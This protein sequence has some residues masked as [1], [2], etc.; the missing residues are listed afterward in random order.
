MTDLSKL[1]DAEIMA[2]VNAGGNVQPIDAASGEALPEAQAQTYRQLNAVGGIDPGAPGGSARLPLAQRDP[3]D[4]PDPGMFYVATDGRVMQAPKAGV[5]TMVDNVMRSTARGVPLLGNWA[6]EGSAAVNAAVAP[7]VE[8]LLRGLE[9]LGVPTPYDDAFRLDEGKTFGDRYATALSLQKLRD[10]GFDNA[11][12]TTSNTAKGVGTVGGIVAGAL[13]TP[14]LAPASTAAGA[15]AGLLTRMGA[16]AI[17]GGILGGIQGAGTGYG[18]ITDPSRAKAAGLEG[19]IG[20]AGGGAFPWVARGLGNA[21]NAT[22][23][24]V[25]A[26]ALERGR[27]GPDVPAAVD[28]AA[29]AR[30]TGGTPGMP[31]GLAE[32]PDRELIDILATL[33]AA[34]P[35]PTVPAEASADAYARI[36]RAAR[37]QGQTPQELADAVTA[38]GNRGVL[39]DTGQSMQDLTRAAM[40][41][42]SG[43]EDIVRGNLDLR[44]MGV[45]EGGTYTAR[46]S[47]LRIVDEAAAGLGANERSYLGN[48]DALNKIQKEAADPLYAQ[49]REIGATDSVRLRD[50]E[51]RPS[52]QKAKAR[53]YRLAK[54]DGRNPEDLALVSVESPDNWV[55]T[56]P[57]EDQAVLQA[58]GVVLKRAPSKANSQGRSLTKFIADN[59]GIRDDGGELRALDGE[60]WHKSKAYQKKLIG[61]ADGADGWGMKAWEAGYFPELA[62][63]PTERQLLDAIADEMRGKPRYTR[64]LDEQLMDRLNR[65]DEA[66]EMLYRGG[67]EAGPRPED[68]TGR[69]MPTDEPV[70]EAVPTAETWDYIKRGLDDELETY[71]NKTT[72]ELVLNDEGRAVQRTLQELR[73]ELVKLNPV[74]GEALKAYSGPAA[75]K[76]ALEAGRGA[77]RETGEGLQRKLA[78]MTTGEREMYR[79]GALQGLREKLGNADV[80]YNAAQRAG[81]LKPNQLERFKELFPSEA[82]FS[83]FVQ[84]LD[85]EAAMFRTRSGLYN[86]SSTAKQLANAGE[87]S[88]DMLSEAVGAAVNLKTGGLPAMVRALAKW[89]SEPKMSEATAEQIAAIL[90]TLDQTKL[91]GVVTKLDTAAAQ[92][93]LLE[94]LRQSGATGVYGPGASAVSSELK[95][96][97][98]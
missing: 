87:D 45:R 29:V 90:T 38:L 14:F 56:L 5:P 61:E 60:L 32:G 28:E 95:G 51:R 79:A 89:G 20:A 78:D 76:D 12:P 74:Y 72:G 21:W 11:Y 49:V 23:G 8:P 48:F 6:D 37:R 57:P 81:I 7:A 59:G 2:L 58:K 13:A 36:A 10:E 75:M 71:R 65:R 82:A 9:N 70:L 52:V 67:P 64:G 25:L 1:S 54:E 86:V 40:N 3:A 50:L 69:P 33:K 17:D 35:A 46:P 30:L 92:T 93:R 55:S 24:K 39:A 96:A 85:Q 91:P 62:E 4:T 26:R 63:R 77:F 97:E 84:T 66:E 15:E 43:A 19:A 47:S 73:G 98:R 83:K 42:P 27:A 16:G 53:A 80:T 34:P 31:A 68:Y 41:R 22:G 44:Q 18:D 88:P 94:A